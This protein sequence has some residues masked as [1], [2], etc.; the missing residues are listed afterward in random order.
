MTDASVFRA[1][2]PVFERLAY[3]NAGTEGP[4]PHS[5][6]EAVRRQ[7]DLEASEG[8]CGRPYFEHV[9]GQAADLRAGYARVLGCEPSEVALTGSTTDGVNTVIAGL[10]LRPGDEILTSDEEH[11]GLL[12][13]L[14]LARRR[15]GVKVRMVPFPEL[16][17]EVS[18]STRLVACS[19]VSWVS[20]RVVDT[21]ALAAAGAPVLL[22]AAQA[23][24]A[25]PVDVG[26]LGCDFYAASGQ[27]WLCGPEGSGCLY[28]RAGRLEDLLIPWPGYG[29][30]ADPAQALELAPAEGAP[31]LDHGFPPG[32]RS[33]WALASLAVFEAAG[34]DWVHERAASLAERL[35]DRLA[36]R[37][38]LVGPRGR[39]TLVS[40]A[41]DDA[42]AEVERL[43]TNGAIVRSIPAFGLVR[44]S[45][46]AWSSDEELDRLLTLA[47]G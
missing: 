43:A 23:I 19:H 7:I 6:A 22:D 13:P 21:R 35:A 26:E 37:G 41:A 39:S 20:G 47:V 11:P 8:R 1:Q 3:L 38:L 16:P 2:F 29:S 31:R 17:G 32:I 42:Q 9:M 14:G 45:V 24:G 30:L 10:D 44:A 33:A 46:G 40:W 12:A 15:H 5:A 27:K 36:E 34:W 25:V 4:V 18:R 28:V